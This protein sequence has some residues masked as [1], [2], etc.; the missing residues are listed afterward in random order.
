M[1]TRARSDR[2]TTRRGVV[3]AALL[4]LGLFASTVRDAAAHGGQYRAPG[5]GFP[6]GM[7]PPTIGPPPPT[8]GETPG[9]RTPAGGGPVTPGEGG[10]RR[11]GALTVKTDWSVWWDAHADDYWAGVAT[12]P[13]TTGDGVDLARLA[14]I[15]RESVV[16][17]FLRTVLA[18]KGAIDPDLVSAT[19]LALGKTTS[20]PDDVD[21]ILERLRSA[22]ADDVEREGAAIA[23]GCL[24]RSVAA[25]RFDG[26]L[27]DRVRAR[28]LD[29][30]DDTSTSRRVRCFA[31]LAVGLL[32]DQPGREDDAFNKDLRTT[33]RALWTRLLEEDDDEFAVAYLV[34]LSMQ[35]PA[36]VPSTA[37][38]A[39]RGLAAS[40]ELLRRPRSDLLQSHAVLAY[41]RLVGD[42]ASGMLL[43]LVKGTRHSGEAIRSAVLALGALATSLD[44]PTRAAAMDAIA[45]LSHHGNPDTIGFALLSLGRLLA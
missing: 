35:P 17:P 16:V 29:A 39:L 8:F 1:R 5:G 40:G 31:I 12:A 22:S 27:L 30:V 3:V 32:G 26:A 11:R 9:G 34:A 33:T 20:C 28:L 7:P 44:A 36:G 15:T 25:S 4:A 14:S 45:Q 23:L 24:R 42:D 37:L 38:T 43:G 10:G 21:R 41:A 13:V 18:T 2:R 6:P 19:T